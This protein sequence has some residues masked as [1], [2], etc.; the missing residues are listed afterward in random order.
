MRMVPLFPLIYS[1]RCV[2]SGY[3]Y[4]PWKLNDGSM[5]FIT[6]QSL[7]WGSQL[8][9]VN[10]ELLMR[11]ENASEAAFLRTLAAFRKA[12]HDLF[13]GG[14]YLGS[15]TPGGDNPVRYIPNYQ[16]TPVVMGARWSSVRGDESLVLVNM[17]SAS[18][19]VLTDGKREVTVPARS[20]LRLN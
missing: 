8:G 2:Y 5:D 20:A 4:I 19:T 14:R 13:F 15:V 17:D 7:L 18:H 12:N 1:D 11:P 16:Q 9:W 6:M 10:P 3:T